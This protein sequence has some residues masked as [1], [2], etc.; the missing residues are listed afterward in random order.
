MSA[1]QWSHRDL[2]SICQTPCIS[3]SN[4]AVPTNPSHER[5][6]WEGSLAYASRVTGESKLDL[7]P[8]S[9]AA[10]LVGSGMLTV[11]LVAIS[12]EGNNSFLEI[13]PWVLVVTIATLGAFASALVRDRYIAGNLAIAATLLFGAVGVL[14]LASIG[15][16]FLMAASMSMLAVIRLSEADAA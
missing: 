14:A 4:P 12:S 15:A 2:L 6:E 7:R 8:W 16:G 3:L 1:A 9:I 11:Y 13:L 10:G 5:S